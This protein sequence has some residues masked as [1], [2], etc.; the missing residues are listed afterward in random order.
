[1][2]N[3]ES[4][5]D[6]Q[7]LI[8]STGV[9]E[10]VGNKIARL[11]ATTGVIKEYAAP[12]GCQPAVMRAETRSKGQTYLWYTCFIGQGMG[13]IN[14]AT[15]ETKFYPAMPLLSFPVEDTVDSR[16]RVWFSTATANSL[17]ALT[18]STGKVRVVSQPDSI[19]A[20]LPLP[21]GLPPAANIAVHYGPKNSIWFSEL[22]RNRVGKFQLV[23]CGNTITPCTA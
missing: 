23:G 13:S 21:G 14:T 19:V 12:L 11:N 4:S 15:G 18:P 2:P 17:S 8:A 1:M 5:R 20:P 9:C 16:G 22:A 3:S 10:F 7:K 6:D